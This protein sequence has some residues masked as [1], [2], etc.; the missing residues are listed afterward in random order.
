MEIRCDSESP[1]G[2]DPA[3]R[4]TPS[5]IQRVCVRAREKAGI[6]APEA[7]AKRRDA[8]IDKLDTV[9]STAK[10]TSPAAYSAAQKALKENEDLTFSTEE[11]DV[12]L[13]PTLRKVRKP[14][15]TS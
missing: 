7:I 10:V 11:I 1:G 8:L 14:E 9:Y 2:E 5:G 6:V 4:L 12:M 15:T 3:G 13:Q